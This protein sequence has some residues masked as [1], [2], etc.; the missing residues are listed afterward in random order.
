MI[1][2]AHA[3]TP[4]T[5]KPIK[6]RSDDPFTATIY[7]GIRRRGSIPMVPSLRRPINS[8]R[9]LL[10]SPRVDLHRQNVDDSFVSCQLTSIVWFQFI[11]VTCHN[12]KLSKSTRRSL[13]FSHWAVIDSRHTLFRSRA[14]VSSFLESIFAPFRRAAEQ[15]C[16][17]IVQ[18]FVFSRHTGRSINQSSCDSVR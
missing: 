8:C 14:L 1:D 11:F 7:S 17:A 10:R 2:W 13:C 16:M 3:T 12:R 6:T 18:W 5:Q 9:G 15:Q 4:V